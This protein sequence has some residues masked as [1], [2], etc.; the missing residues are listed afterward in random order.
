MKDKKEDNE[1]VTYIVRCKDKTL[2]TGW[3][4]NIQKRLKAHNSSQGAKYTKGRTPVT[5]VYLEAHKTRQEAMQREVS[6]KKLSR[7]QKEA[8]ILQYHMINGNPL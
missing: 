8:L 3:T 2:Y 4:N 1:N 7:V 6:I 5:L